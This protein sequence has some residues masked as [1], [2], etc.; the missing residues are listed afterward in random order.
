MKDMQCSEAESAAYHPVFS[1]PGLTNQSPITASVTL[2]PRLTKS[3]L[4]HKHIVKNFA[5]PLIVHHILYFSLIIRSKKNKAFLGCSNIYIQVQVQVLYMPSERHRTEKIRRKRV[6]FSKYF[7]RGGRGR[8]GVECSAPRTHQTLNDFLCV[9]HCVS[10]S[11][12]PSLSAQPGL[13]RGGRG[14]ACPC[15]SPRGRAVGSCGSPSP[16]RPPAR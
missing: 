12:A 7:E 1:A 2:G 16:W 3:E 15:L 8:G 14:C 9:R 10:F 4:I 13:T 5:K 11:P 6:S